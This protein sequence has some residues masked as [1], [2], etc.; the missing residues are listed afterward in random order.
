MSD[1]N[2]N[3]N[4]ENIISEGSAEMN[5]NKLL[6]AAKDKI[7]YLSGADDLSRMVSDSEGTQGFPFSINAESTSK[8]FRAFADAIDKHEVLLQKEVTVQIASNQDFSMRV[9]HI[10]YAA[11]R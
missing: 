5:Q 2:K 3:F 1:S 7:S 10:H 4:N 9:L 8:F 6:E 11:K